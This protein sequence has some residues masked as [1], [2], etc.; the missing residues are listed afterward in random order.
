MHNP[1]LDPEVLLDMTQS[2]IEGLGVKSGGPAKSVGDRWLVL[3]GE[4]LPSHIETYRQVYSE[5]AV[6]T[7]FTKILMVFARGRV[8][9]LAG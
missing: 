1:D 8:E 5:L 3:A 4:D 7:R 2:L 6:P 9:T